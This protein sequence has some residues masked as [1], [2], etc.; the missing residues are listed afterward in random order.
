MERKLKKKI[1]E[2]TTSEEME[3]QPEDIWKWL[4]VCIPVI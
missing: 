2:N 4:L 1:L 3:P